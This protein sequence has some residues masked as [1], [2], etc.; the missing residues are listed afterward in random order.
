MV[1]PRDGHLN[2]EGVRAV[3][4]GAPLAP[5]AMSWPSYNL[6]GPRVRHVCDSAAEVDDESRTWDPFGCHVILSFL[7]PSMISTR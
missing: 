2:L 6:H 1:G 5:G 7:P 4:L 3:C